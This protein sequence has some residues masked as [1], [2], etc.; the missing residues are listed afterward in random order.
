MEIG[1]FICEI[2]QNSFFYFQ[3]LL[4]LNKNFQAID[5]IKYETKQLSAR[6][7][8]PSKQCRSDPEGVLPCLPCWALGSV[9]TPRTAPHG[10]TAGCLSIWPVALPEPRP[11]HGRSSWGWGQT[12]VCEFGAV[13]VTEGSQAPR[14]PKGVFCLFTVT[15]RGH[16]VLASGLGGEARPLC[17]RRPVS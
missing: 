1:E 14:L 11:F 17:S 16:L 9:E 5:V 10:N 2:L 6:P 4:K 15:R 13:A 8:P 3:Y 12:G 7:P